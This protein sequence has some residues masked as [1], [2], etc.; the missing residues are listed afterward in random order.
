VHN[1]YPSPDTPYSRR[2]HN[3]GRS[4]QNHQHPHYA[5]GQNYL[6][7][8]VFPYPSPSRKL[9]AQEEYEL[10]PIGRFDTFDMGMAPVTRNATGLPMIFPDISLPNTGQ[11]QIFIEPSAT[12]NSL[13]N[14]FGSIN[15]SFTGYLDKN[16]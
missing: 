8:S 3:L 6:T 13:A 7:A 9:P 14:D 11:R 10:P 1:V 2:S 16:Q 5:E 15:Y 12:T 4:D